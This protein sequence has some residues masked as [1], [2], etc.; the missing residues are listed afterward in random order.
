MC[1][2]LASND[3]KYFFSYILW[4]HLQHMEVPSQWLNLSCICD[5]HCSCGNARSFNPLCRTRNWTCAFTVNQAA[6][7]GFL[8]HCTTVGTPDVGYFH[9]CTYWLFSYTFFVESLAMF[10]LI[11]LLVCGNYLYI[12]H[13]KDF[14]FYCFL[15]VK[16]RSHQRF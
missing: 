15:T 2:S 3:V 12:L 8:T 16:G 6:A 11:T 7:V 10:L 13:T 1:I 9:T 5:L 4:P 14:W